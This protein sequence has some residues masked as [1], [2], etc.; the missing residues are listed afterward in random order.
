M[1]QWLFNI[2]M[3]GVVREIKAR[4]SGRGLSLVNADDRV[5]A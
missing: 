5:E 2:Y 3:G 1:L 4:M